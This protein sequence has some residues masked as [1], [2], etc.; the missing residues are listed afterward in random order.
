MFDWYKSVL[1][2]YAEFGGRARRS[3]FWYFTLVNI[4]ILIVLEVLASAIHGSVGVVFLALASI[5]ALAVFVPTLAVTVRRLH[6]TGR[7]GW[8]YFI[9][10]VP[11]VGVIILLVFECADSVPGTNQWGPNPK[12]AVLTPA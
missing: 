4:I 3:E 10:L 7:S 2:K 11:A 1:S 6:D 5:Y 9:A 12:E 8:W